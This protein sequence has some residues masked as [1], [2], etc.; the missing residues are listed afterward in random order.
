M[1]KVTITV[2]KIVKFTRR[3]RKA[4]RIAITVARLR[5]ARADMDVRRRAVERIRERIERINS[6]PATQAWRGTAE[7]AAFAARMKEASADILLMED[8]LDRFAKTLGSS[9]DKWEKRQ[10]EANAKAEDLTPPRG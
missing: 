7:G 5:A 8:V 2:I 4:Q 3:V 6:N 1:A 10:R 9:A